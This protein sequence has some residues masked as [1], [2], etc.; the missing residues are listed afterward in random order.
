L[1]LGELHDCAGKVHDVLA[2]LRE[3]VE[4]DKE[5]ICGDFPLSLCL[6]LVLKVGILELGTDIKG[7]SEL[8][9]S[10]LLVVSLDEVENSKAVDGISAPDD[11]GVADLSDQDDE[12][13]WGI[14]VLRILPN[15]QDCLHDW[16]KEINYFRK[17]GTCADQIIEEI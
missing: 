1:E 8:V 17:I 7:N 3:G 10:L 5:G 6:L 16:S 14:V 12:S 4:S 13:G 11:D 2:S 9:V 15:K